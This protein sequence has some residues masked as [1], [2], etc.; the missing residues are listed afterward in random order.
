MA[1]RI[2]FG[3][4]SLAILALCVFNYAIELR[5][6][7]KAYQREYYSLLADK[8]KDPDKAAEVAT[9]PA[10]FSQ[11]YNPELGVVD[12][13]TICHLGMENPQMDSRRIRTKSIQETCLPRIR[14]RKSVARTVTKVKVWRQLSKTCTA[15][16]RLGTTRS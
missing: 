7:W 5:P 1:L 4:A 11:I 12:R 10:R 6:D 13:C 8:I 15:P 9:T 14:I 3:I 16:C 2:F